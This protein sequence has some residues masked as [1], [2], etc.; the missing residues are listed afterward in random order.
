M[1]NNTSLL[2]RSRKGMVDIAVWVL[3]VLLGGALFYM[4]YTKDALAKPVPPPDD[5]GADKVIPCKEGYTRDLNGN[6]IISGSSNVP[7]PQGMTRNTNGVCVSQETTIPNVPSVCQPSGYLKSAYVRK[8]ENVGGIA[9][10]EFGSYPA[11]MTYQF[12][13][14]SDCETN[15]YFEGGLTQSTP[16]T[17]LVPS[18]SK[19]DGNTHFAGKWIRMSKNTILN[20]NNPPGL[21][22][23]AFFPLDYGETGRFRVGGG[24]FTGCFKDGGKSIAV[25]PDTSINIGR[26][27]SGADISN[28]WVK[29]I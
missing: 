10:N 9:Q 23:I 16:L 14:T 15:Y 20:T 2:V 4:V 24:V 26:G 12:Q 13:V 7:C 25:I 11:I 6:C 28:S 21:V 27:Y 18:G 19:C 17:L 8:L 3:I 1:R 5:S 29:V 22:D